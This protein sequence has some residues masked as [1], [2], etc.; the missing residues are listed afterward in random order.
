MFRESESAAEHPGASLLH[1]GVHTAR[2]A[3]LVYVS[4]AMPGIARLRVGRTFRYLTPRRHV[5]R[6]RSTLR[7][8]SALA[9]PPAYR[10]VWICNTP[11]G[12]L[13]ATGRDARGRKQY[14]YHV[15][16]REI[17]DGAK[18]DRMADFVAALPALRRRLQRDLALKELCRDKVLACAVTILSTSAARVGNAEYARDNNSFGITTLRSRHVSFARG[19]R[20]T[21][22]FVG[23]GRVRHE[24]VVDRKRIV[25]I[26]RRCHSL[27]GYHLFQYLDPDGKCRP[28]DSGMVNAYLNEAMGGDFTAKDFRTWHATVHAIDLLR[29]LPVPSRKPAV[30]RA[31]VSVLKSVARLLRNTPAVCRKSYVNPEVFTSWE[32][33]VL[34]ERLGHLARLNGRRAERALIRFLR[35]T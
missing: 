24:I 25:D 16:W 32:K 29:S 7:R 12:H 23:K 30:R 10:D 6:D 2:R 26:V 15:A 35:K 14:R 1:Q 22:D 8:I 18:F 27:P 11:R 34:Q 20:A 31:C 4:D 3:G 5:I 13:Q 21:L 33:G 9:V 17:R 19:G 28:I